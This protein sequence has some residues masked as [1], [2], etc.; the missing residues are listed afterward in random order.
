MAKKEKKQTKLQAAELRI[1][2]LEDENTNFRN[3]ARAQH[4]I[5]VGLRRVLKPFC[6]NASPDAFKGYEGNMTNCLV[7]DVDVQRARQILDTRFQ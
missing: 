5:I 1:L 2:V 7:Q 4:E 3:N 6:F